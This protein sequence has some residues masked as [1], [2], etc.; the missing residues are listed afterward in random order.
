MLKDA[1]WAEEEAEGRR[2]LGEARVK[3]Y[4]FKQMLRLKNHETGHTQVKPGYITSMKI[5]RQRID[6]YRCQTCHTMVLEGSLQ[7]VRNVG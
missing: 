4:N 2:E 3:W 5:L 7:R 1:A 6:G